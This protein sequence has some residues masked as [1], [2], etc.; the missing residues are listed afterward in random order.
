MGSCS[1]FSAKHPQ[2]ISISHLIGLI[3]PIPRI[4]RKSWFS[5]GFFFEASASKIFPNIQ[6]K[7]ASVSK[8]L[9]FCVAKEYKTSRHF[10]NL[11][12]FSDSTEKPPWTLR[13][14]ILV[15]G[16]LNIDGWFNNPTNSVMY[17]KL[18]VPSKVHGFCFDGP[19]G[20]LPFTLTFQP[21]IASTDS[22][23]QTPVTVKRVRS[24]S[25]ASVLGVQVDWVALKVVTWSRWRCF[26]IWW[27]DDLLNSRKSNKTWS[28]FGKG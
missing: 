4:S 2:S 10:E 16:T 6:V 22:T 28:F 21:R 13:L 1:S 23:W 19:T 26:E 20:W 15:G 24:N 9:R 18:L 12:H 25:H 5:G 8:N 3:W 27:W 14:I 11:V 7:Q 17:L